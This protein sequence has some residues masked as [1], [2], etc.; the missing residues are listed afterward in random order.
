MDHTC[1]ICKT[2]NMI[3]LSTEVHQIVAVA[4]EGLNPALF[5]ILSPHPSPSRIGKCGNTVQKPVW[6]VETSCIASVLLPSITGSPSVRELAVSAPLSL[7]SL[8][9]SHLHC[10]TVYRH[11]CGCTLSDQLL[12]LWI[13]WYVDLHWCLCKCEHMNVC[14]CACVCICVCACVCV[15][16]HVCVCLCWRVHVFVCVF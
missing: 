11:C 5:H 14:V 1:H 9:V 6:C 10:Y 12:I 3:V 13:K 2:I 15:C 4:V 8:C 16:V 7:Y